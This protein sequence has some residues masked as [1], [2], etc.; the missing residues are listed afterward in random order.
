MLSKFFALL[1]LSTVALLLAPFAA[2]AQDVALRPTVVDLNS[3]FAEIT[4]Y[5]LALFGAV[6]TAAITWATKKLSDWTGI[7]IEANHREALQSALM[8]GARFALAKATPTELKLDLKNATLASA[9]RFVLDSVPDA[10]AYF[11]L[12]PEDIERHLAPKVAAILSEK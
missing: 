6:I 10:V 5:I 4:P 7:T 9:V 1:V 3:F 11:G 8:N 12:T 2:L